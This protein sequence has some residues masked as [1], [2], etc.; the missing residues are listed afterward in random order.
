MRTKINVLRAVLATVGRRA[1]TLVV[2]IAGAIMVVLF[3]AIWA[4]AYFFSHWWWLLLVVYIPLLLIYLIGSVI[5]RF[6]VRSLYPGKLSKDQTSLV[7]NFTDKIQLLLE[8]RGIGWPMF[9]L[10]NVKDLIFHR[11]LRTTKELISNTVSIK[12]DFAE[13]EEKLQP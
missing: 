11:E 2:V 4:L 7:D 12:R 3:S 13:L 10:L 6:I 8:T 9:A 5:G 1:L